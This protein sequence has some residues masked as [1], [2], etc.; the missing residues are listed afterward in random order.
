MNSR[1]SAFTNSRAPILTLLLMCMCS[2]AQQ[3]AGDGVFAEEFEKGAKAFQVGK[4]EDAISAFKKANK[5]HQNSCAECYFRMAGAYAQIGD[6]AQALDSADKFL[7]LSSDGPSHGLAHSLKGNVYLALG[8]SESNKLKNAE[9]EYRLA[10][11]L[12]RNNPPYHFNLAKAFLLESRDAEANQNCK[13][14]S[15]SQAGLCV[16]SA[17]YSVN[18]GSAKGP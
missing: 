15:I 12:D 8:K 4:Y 16:D 9:E 5:L 17:G 18:G 14:A 1:S 3:S 10:T 7:A 11:Q 13:S 6:A 2:Q